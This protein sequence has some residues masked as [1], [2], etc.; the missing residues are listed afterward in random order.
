MQPVSNGRRKEER[1]FSDTRPQNDI[2]SQDAHIHD[3]AFQATSAGYM[4]Q[5]AYITRAV[6][7][8][9]WHPLRA[10]VERALQESE[11]A[12]LSAPP[13]GLLPWPLGA[14]EAPVGAAKCGG[15]TLG[16][17]ATGAIAHL[18]DQSGRQW[19]AANQTLA[20]FR[21]RSH[22]EPEFNAYGDRYMLPGCRSAEDPGLCGFGKQ[23]LTSQAGAVNQD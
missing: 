12:P 17:D 20:R 2:L 9:G 1:G 19:A 10:Q 8:L 13:P 11:P 22:S 4:D 6:V 14:S 23:G 15:L 16:I 5:R 7:T 21:Y 18:V 3:A